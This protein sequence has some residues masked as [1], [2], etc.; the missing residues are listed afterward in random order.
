MIGL[1]IGRYVGQEHDEN[2][3]SLAD[4][5]RG[6]IDQQTFLEVLNDGG[7]EDKV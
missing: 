2:H 3:E 5:G 7:F 6:R 1:Q 4:D